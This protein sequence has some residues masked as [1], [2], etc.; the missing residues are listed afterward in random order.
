M[1]NS[2]GNLAGATDKSTPGWQEEAKRRIALRAA[3]TKRKTERSNGTFLPFDDPFRALLD[4]AAKRRGLSMVGYARR[5]VA[6]MIAHDLDLPFT[7]VIQ[8]A[9]QPAEYGKSGGA[10]GISKRSNDN[11]LGFGSW[12][13]L[14]LK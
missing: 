14:R 1:A 10:S 5:A 3:N 6:A 4:E 2:R 8:H 11:G 13:I 7:E 12:K 9:P